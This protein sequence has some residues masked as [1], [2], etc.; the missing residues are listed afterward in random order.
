MSAMDSGLHLTR[1]PQIRGS[2]IVR[3]KTPMH[4][5]R[6][7]RAILTPEIRAPLFQE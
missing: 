4:T 3:C 7:Q 5:S 2:N 6:A 1:Y